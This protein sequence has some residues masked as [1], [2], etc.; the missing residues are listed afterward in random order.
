V[1]CLNRFPQEL[2]TGSATLEVG[3]R[4]ELAAQEVA[5]MKSS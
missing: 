1:A 2:A 5:T 4:L 3:K